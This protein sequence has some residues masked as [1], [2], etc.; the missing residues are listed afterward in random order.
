MVIL[1]L[2]EMAGFHPMDRGFSGL[3][4]LLLNFIVCIAITCSGGPYY[5][6]I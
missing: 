4:V 1:S 5:D 6:R 2:D 3:T